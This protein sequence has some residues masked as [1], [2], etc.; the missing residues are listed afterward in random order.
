MECDNVEL[1][2]KLIA[3]DEEAYN[4]IFKQ[5]YKSL[6]IFSSHYSGS[7]ESEEIVQEVMLWL[8]ENRSFLPQ[9]VSIKSFLFAA[10]K[11]K[12]INA[13]THTR[14]K[15][16]VLTELLAEYS[17]HF[18]MP[19]GY[20]KYEREELIVFLTK[21]L[22]ALPV[23][24]RDAF[25]RN[26][27]QNMTYNEIAREAGVSPKTIAYRI[28]QTLKKLRLTFREYQLLIILCLGIGG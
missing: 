16:R 28:S 8:W 10:V 18:H 23:E 20:E 17:Q 4:V 26:R 7:E 15:N 24:Y 22:K 3:G 14:I 13:I 27:F 9:E 5:Y 21:A 1:T 2:Q 11:N 12:C 6:C 19:D 25:E